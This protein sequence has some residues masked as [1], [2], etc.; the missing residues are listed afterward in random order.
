MKLRVLNK[1][2]FSGVLIGLFIVACNTE[3]INPNLSLSR[4]S[5]SFSE[6]GGSVV[7]TAT[8][9]TPAP[10]TVTIPLIFGGTATE[11]TDYTVSNNTLTILAGETL[12]SITISSLQ[13][14]N[15]EGTETISITLNNAGGYLLSGGAAVIQIL[16]DDIDSDNDGILDADDDCPNLSGPI[17][18]NGCPI[19]GIIF[20]E[21][22]YD[23]ADDLAGDANGDGIRSALGDEFIEFFNAG[24]ALD[25][26]GYTV[27]DA[28]QIRHT[29]PAGTI[30]PQNRRV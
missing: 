9:E 18:N 22:N 15:V 5:T 16:D 27:S 20:N 10:N 30:I 4:S 12:G 24:P 8:L 19:L 7:I 13:D 29:F 17:S 28:S 6:A 26:S 11:G 23:P 1:R 21:V 2:F 14:T 3:D 25:I